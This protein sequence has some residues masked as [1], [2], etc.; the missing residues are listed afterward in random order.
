MDL[1]TVWF[2][3]FGLRVVGRRENQYNLHF[4][5]VHFKYDYFNKHTQKSKLS[6]FILHHANYS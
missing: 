2:L 4:Y 3:C 5:F 6:F 1:W